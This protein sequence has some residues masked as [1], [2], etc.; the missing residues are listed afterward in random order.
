VFVARGATL[1][2]QLFRRLRR[3]RRADGAAAAIVQF[4]LKLACTI[5]QNSYH[6]RNYRE[7]RFTMARRTK[8]EL[9]DSVET[10]CSLSSVVT[11]GRRRPLMVER[12]EQIV[13]LVA[14][15]D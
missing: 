8:N 3:A 12:P 2:A 1:A 10:I 14:F 15:A 13:W 6:V 5:A 9:D 11:R 4:M 7:S